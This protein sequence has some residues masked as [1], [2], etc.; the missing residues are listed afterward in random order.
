[1]TFALALAAK[2]ERT[3]INERIA[4]ARTRIEASGGAWGRPQRVKGDLLTQ[5]GGLQAQGRTIRKISAALKVPRSTI[6]RALTLSQNVA[7][8]G[9]T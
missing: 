2:I 7:S 1:M 6:A 8:N 3:A 5:A 4:S 9:G